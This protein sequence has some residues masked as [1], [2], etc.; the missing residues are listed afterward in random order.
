MITESV[1]YT[2]GRSESLCALFAFA[3]GAWS[4]ALDKKVLVA[5]CRSLLCLCAMLSK[6]LVWFCPLFL[7]PW[8]HAG[9]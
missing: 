8:M 6:E 9:T 1:I 4:T 2:T 7:H 5:T 3:L